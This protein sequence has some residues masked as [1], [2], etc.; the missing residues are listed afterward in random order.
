MSRESLA[1]AALGAHPEALSAS[2]SLATP[3]TMNRLVGRDR[4]AAFLRELAE[5]F[6]IAQPE[7]VLEGEERHV[8]TFAGSVD[9]H[10]VG[11]LVVL[12][13]GPEGTYQAVDAYARPWPF[14][15][16]ARDKMVPV[17]QVLAEDIDVSTPYVP[18]GP[19]D[20]YLDLP[21]AAPRLATDVAFHSPVLTA[22]VSGR[23]RVAAVLQAVEQVGG[24]PGYRI[25]TQAGEHV[26]AAY[27]L[28]VHG[29]TWQVAAVFRFNGDAEIED[30]LIYSRPW[31]VTAFFR[32]EI[33]K[34]LR[35]NYGPEFWQ[36]ENPLTALG[37][38]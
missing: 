11:L 23:D 28:H 8:V 9:G 13:P 16:L 2:V 32:G 21:A 19:A 25:F 27:D 5:A 17:D 4:A 35:P 1:R 38:D 15:A 20:G 22:T 3:L 29:H 37:E 31:P 18:S 12:T 30:M 34:L 10:P 36:G 33:F 24:E 26:V 6:S 14:V 7:F